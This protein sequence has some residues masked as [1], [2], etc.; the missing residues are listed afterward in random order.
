MGV[1]QHV[2]CQLHMFIAMLF[3]VLYQTAC[4]ILSFIPV[5]F[6]DRR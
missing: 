6:A 4:C 3:S 5:V 2:L 1:L